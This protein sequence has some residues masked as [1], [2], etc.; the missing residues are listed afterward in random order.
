MT[1]NLSIIG[2]GG[3]AKV[4]MESLNYTA[5]D[6]KVNF[7]DETI[8]ASNVLL[9]KYRVSPLKDFEVLDEYFHVAIGS[10]SLRARI[11]QDAIILKK[12]FLTI[13]HR[14]A[15]VSANALIRE[16]VFLAANSIVA[17]EA[18][19]KQG[20]IIN[21]AAIVDHDCII[22][23]FSHIAPNSTL[24]GGVTIG[25]QC[26]IGAGAI[27]LPNISIGDFSVIGAGSVVTK[28]IPKYGK[29]A[30]NPAIKIS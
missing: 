22:G 29:F 23:K 8:S 21:H 9:E 25:K 26:L 18:I 2:A 6:Y 15:V 19:I 1:I 27:I 4:V 16:G 13:S 11:S 7:F 14:L 10:N 17:S 12:N 28:N 3:H 30:G 20:C 5:K 24:G